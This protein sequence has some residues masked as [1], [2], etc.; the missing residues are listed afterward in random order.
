MA[1]IGNL[2]PDFPAAQR[3]PDDD[4]LS[5]ARAPATQQRQCYRAVQHRRITA[6]THMAL[7]IVHGWQRAFI[8]QMRAGGEFGSRFNC[9]QADQLQPVR[10]LQRL[11]SEQRT[12][13]VRL[14]LAGKLTHAKIVRRDPSIDLGMR[15]KAL[16]NAHDAHGFGAVCGDAQWLAQP[17]QMLGNLI[18]VICRYGQFVGQFAGE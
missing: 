10:L 14:F 3:I 12:A 5:M 13:Q 17:H 16:L 4:C 2:R 11:A 9:L 6:R 8:E 7:I 1:R 15:D 18:A